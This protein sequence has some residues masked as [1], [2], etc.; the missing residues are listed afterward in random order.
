[1][2]EAIPREKPLTSQRIGEKS[3]FPHLGRAQ[4]GVD[5]A[6]PD[7]PVMTEHSVLIWCSMRILGSCPGGMA[8]GA[9]HKGPKLQ[10]E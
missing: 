4:W 2:T 6:L 8:T 10:G 3:T 7:L 5:L 1:M 9:L